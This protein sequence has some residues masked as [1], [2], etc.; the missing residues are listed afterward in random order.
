MLHAYPAAPKSPVRPRAQPHETSIWLDLESPSDDEIAT[1]EGL[2]GIRLPTLKDLSEIEFSSRL[3]RDGDVLY[4]S[5]PF[6]SGADTPDYEPSPVGFVITPERL[7]TIRYSRFVAFDAAVAN[8]TAEDRST[9]MGVFTALLEAVVD[10]LA[11]LLE[12]VS[13]ELDTVSRRAFREDEVQKRR[14]ARSTQIQ[15]QALSRVGGLGDRLSQ[16]RDALLGVERMVAYVSE[17]RR[18]RHD[19]EVM[20]RLNAIHA[21]L[22]SLS[23]Y[24]NRLSDKIQFL[25]DAILG[26]ISVQQNDIFKVLTIASVVGIPP[27][28][29]A[30]MYGMNFVSMPE[31][32]WK[33]GYAYGL[34]MIGIS[35]IIP[36]AWFKWRGWL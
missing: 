34:A 32:H 33:F 17:I 20:L 11:D 16:I 13:A 22:T 4:L 28:F 5:A 35:T 29:L 36:L 10:R 7:V 21:D 2:L 23:D 18:G 1:V 25:L 14:S 15:R 27:T 19:E 26:F 3:R 24:E 8:L 31:Y 6:V 12:K 9:T 30:S